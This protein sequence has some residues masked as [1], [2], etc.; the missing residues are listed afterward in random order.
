MYKNK[1]GKMSTFLRDKKGVKIKLSRDDDTQVFGVYL[2]VN[3]V[4][5]CGDILHVCRYFE[6]A[7]GLWMAYRWPKTM[8]TPLY[9]DCYIPMSAAPRVAQEM[10]VLAGVSDIKKAPDSDEKKKQMTEYHKRLLGLA[11]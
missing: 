3:N 2:Y 4:P 8:K 1:A 6:D 9:D 11:D 7:E 5:G 10:L